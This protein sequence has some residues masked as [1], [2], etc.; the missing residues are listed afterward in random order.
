MNDLSSPAPV[1]VSRHSSKRFRNS[2]DQ[3]HVLRGLNPNS[4]IIPRSSRYVHTTRQ[5]INGRVADS[6]VYDQKVHPMDAFTQNSR[7]RNSRKRKPYTSENDEIDYPGSGDYDGV[8]SEHGS[9]SGETDEETEDTPKGERQSSRIAAAVLVAETKPLYDMRKHP[10]D[11]KLKKLGV[12]NYGP[13]R[14]HGIKSGIK[15]KTTTPKPKQHEVVITIS[16]TDNDDVS[17]E[18]MPNVFEDEPVELP[19]TLE[20]VSQNSAAKI[21][22]KSTLYLNVRDQID[23]NADEDNS[24]PIIKK[25]GTPAQ[26]IMHQPSSMPASSMSSSSKSNALRSGRKPNFASRPTKTSLVKGKDMRLSQRAEATQQSPGGYTDALYVTGEQLDQGEAEADDFSVS[27]GMISTEDDGTHKSSTKETNADIFENL[28]PLTWSKDEGTDPI[29]SESPATPIKAVES[30]EKDTT[31]MPPMTM[32]EIE[33]TIYSEVEDFEMPNLD[34]QSL[35][36]M[37]S[38]G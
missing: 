6:V 17:D 31:I 26:V 3:R 7:Y 35:E 33:A 19:Q 23:S 15:D 2:N 4:V 8:E 27:S 30:Q 36:E 9:S 24:T 38:F 32:R 25:Q 21:R 34:A 10:Q 29:E 37:F 12:G 18:D 11:R 20:S 28:N 22:T 14:K 5:S 16:S 13:R 1:R